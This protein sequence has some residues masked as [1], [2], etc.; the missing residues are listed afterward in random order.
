MPSDE[1]EGESGAATEE[2]EGRSPDESAAGGE[3]GDSGAVEVV[4]LEEG[5]GNEPCPAS[6]G[7]NDVVAGAIENLEDRV[8][9]LEAFAVWAE[10]VFHNLKGWLPT[11]I[12]PPP[13]PK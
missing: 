6:R 3:T 11:K 12:P 5:E 9:N 8:A 2:E 7:D 4:T 13:L 10:Q 1:T